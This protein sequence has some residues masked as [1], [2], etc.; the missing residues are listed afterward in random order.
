MVLPWCKHYPDKPMLLRVSACKSDAIAYG[1]ASLTA[2]QVIPLLLPVSPIAVAIAHNLN[3][4]LET[5]YAR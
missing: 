1:I 3:Q 5:N 4:H 2:T